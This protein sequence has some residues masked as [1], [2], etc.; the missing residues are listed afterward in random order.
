PLRQRFDVAPFRDVGPYA[1]RRCA[2][3]SQLGFCPGEARLLDVGEDYFH[4]G[5][6]T[7]FGHPTSDSARGTGNRRDLA[8]KLFHFGP[9]VQSNP[10]VRRPRDCV[11]PAELRFCGANPAV[12]RPELYRTGPAGGPRPSRRV[13][14]C[15]PA[16]RAGTNRARLRTPRSPRADSPWRRSL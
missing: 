11:I 4:A 10:A 3:S 13:P 12:F 7:A 15:R 8:V 9:E 1:K 5:T 16:N 6:N 2:S 14:G